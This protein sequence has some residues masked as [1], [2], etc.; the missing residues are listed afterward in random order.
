MHYSYWEVIIP[1]V[2]FIIL[3]KLMK[4]LIFRFIIC[5]RTNN[6]K[7]DMLCMA[8]NIIANL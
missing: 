2:R 5:W 8:D 7:S 1:N 6:E 4:K 3:Q